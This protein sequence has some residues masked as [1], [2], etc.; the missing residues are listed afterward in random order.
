ML[1]ITIVIGGQYFS[2]NAGVAAGLYSSMIAN[3]LVAAAYITLCCC[4]AEITGALP[5]AGGAYGL[6]RCTLGFYPAFM[7][8]C[9]EALEYIVYVSSSVISFADMVVEVAPSLASVRPL[10]WATFYA[11]A[12]FFHMKSVRLFWAFNAA[13]GSVSLAV[14]LL[15][16]FGALPYVD[17][18]QYAHA[19]S[20]LYFVGGFSSFMKAL[21]L[22][23]W[24]FVG[25]EAL[26]LAS[27]QV[28]Q[29]KAT[30][31]FAQVAC[32]LTLFTTGVMVFFV[33]VSLPPGIAQLPTELVPFNNC[34][35][36]LF[37]LSHRFATVLS[38][39]A[40]YAT[41][42]GFMWC[43]GKLI[44]AMATSRLLPPFLGRTSRRHGSPNVAIIAGSVL[45]YLFCLL[46]YLV[47]TIS[48]RLYMICI[49]CA[50]MSYTGQCVGYISLKKNYRNIK[51]SSFRNPFG[52]Y[53][54]VFSM[55]VWL[56]AFVG[57]A[58]FQGNGGVEVLTFLSAAALLSVF[59]FAYARKRQTFSPQEN[60]ILLVAH[61][62]KFNGLRARGK[63]QRPKGSSGASGTAGTSR[64]TRGT[65]G[66][67][68]TEGAVN[69]GDGQTST[70]DAPSRPNAHVVRSSAGGD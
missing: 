22:A 34:F 30:I 62:T 38:L 9:C 60:R 47:P 69:D 6:A 2:W 8:G 39:P 53:G 13:I 33:T 64:A 35:R 66:S 70:A 4:I 26:N 23:P 63:N 55:S 57:V 67:R 15:Y 50:F 40:T 25:V 59:Y 10:V 45:S 49:T 14:V 3:F 61:V 7:I 19:D 27:D 11:S 41:A 48:A 24:F 1:G 65:V 37:G 32:V 5:F 21:P 28:T 36:P 16:S 12:L 58:G 56:L 44:A 51:S 18:Q 29:P 17:F 52:I 20:S 68:F 43:Y 46:V 31:P 54:A 42:F